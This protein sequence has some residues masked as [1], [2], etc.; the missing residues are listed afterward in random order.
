MTVTGVPFDG[1]GEFWGGFAFTVICRTIDSIRGRKHDNDTQIALS[2]KEW[3]DLIDL[4]RK[5]KMVHDATQQFLDQHLE[6]L[7]GSRSI[8]L[9]NIDRI[10]NA[11]QTHY[12]RGYKKNHIEKLQIEFART[13]EVK[14]RA[15]GL[16]AI[17]TGMLDNMPGEMRS[18]VKAVQS[19]L[20]QALDKLAVFINELES[21]ARRI[22]AKPGQGGVE[23]RE[24]KG[25]AQSDLRSS[26][27]DQAEE[28]LGYADTVLVALIYILDDLYCHVVG[29][30]V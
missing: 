16:P 28:L 13:Q 1:W 7:F 6:N 11:W 22:H 24:I 20:P 3:K 25:W 12:I 14:D 4:L 18:Q 17:D 10:D 29:K 19:I 21:Q 23:A 26:L 9:T 8:R 30:R 15:D 27:K 2:V 5:F